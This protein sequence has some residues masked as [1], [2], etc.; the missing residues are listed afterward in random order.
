MTGRGRWSSGRTIEVSRL[1]LA[2][3]S[4]TTLVATAVRSDAPVRVAALLV[5]GAAAVLV[6]RQWDVVQ[7]VSLV[8][9]LYPVISVLVPLLFLY[10]IVKKII[11]RR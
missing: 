1:E 3:T 11:L 2:G 4:T 9:V 7:S 8:G 10:L 6:A 5:V